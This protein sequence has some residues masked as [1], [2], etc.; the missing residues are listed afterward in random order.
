MATARNDSSNPLFS[1]LADPAVRRRSAGRRVRPD[2]SDTIA[3]AQALL[4][5]G[6]QAHEGI[7][8]DTR[9]LLLEQIEPDP[10]QPRRHFESA[11]IQALAEDIARRGVLQSI[12]VRPPSE[13]GGKYRLVAGERRWRAALMAG[14]T[15]IP[16]RIVSL[17]DEEVQE[18]QLAENIQR[19]D[20]S[21]IEKG[22]AL[23]R[24]YELRKTRAPRSTWE[25]VAAEVGLGRAR[26]HDLYHLAALPEPIAT[27]I[28]TGRLS[29][30][31]GTLLYRAQETLE[32]AE[33]IALAEAAA[34]P[35]ATRRG[36]YQMSVARLRQVLHAQKSPDTQ[37]ETEHKALNTPQTTS[38]SPRDFVQRVVEAIENQTLTLTERELLTQLLLTQH[39][40][41]IHNEFPESPEERQEAGNPL[42]VNLN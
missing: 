5:E 22:R 17:Q 36:A 23:R 13:M 41:S 7:P 10:L 3:E 4:E 35:E 19:K 31:H 12:L 32:E 28:E 27:L 25:D 16:A 20:L 34:R 33:L 40:C 8:E 14:K 30:S 26:I 9:N 18:A 15:R 37:G 11:D 1:V 42:S 24:L 21:D 2:L 29:G 38:A 6:D 39:R